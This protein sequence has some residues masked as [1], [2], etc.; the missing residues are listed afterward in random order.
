MEYV[1]QQ[2]KCNFSGRSLIFPAM[3]QFYFVFRIYFFK[4]QTNNI[5]SLCVKKGA[6]LRVKNQYT[7]LRNCSNQGHLQRG[8]TLY[9]SNFSERME[10]YNVYRPEVALKYRLN[11]Q[12]DKPYSDHWK[13]PDTQY[14]PVYSS[15]SSSYLTLH[16]VPLRFNVF[17]SLPASYIIRWPNV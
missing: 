7:C 1:C 17:R 14:H 5:L 9:A 8:I 4:K 12:I 15:R 3:Y 10:N 11:C 13:W 6:F 2:N 16:A